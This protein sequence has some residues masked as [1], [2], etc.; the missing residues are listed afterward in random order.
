MNK[1]QIPCQAVCN[2]LHIYDFIVELRCIRRLER[3][4]IARRLQFK[5]VTI[6]P[7]GQSPK[8]KGAICN[9]PIDVVSTCNTVPRPADS[10]D[11][12]I[13]KLKRKLEYRGHVYFEP[14]H[15]RLIFRILQFL[16]KNNPLYPDININLSNIPDC[17]TQHNKENETFLA[18]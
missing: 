7:K 12:V 4:L 5:K 13:V 16:K 6:I 11:L 10:N 3:I 15:P 8:F 14:V 17:L 2:K 1:N 18:V 9:I